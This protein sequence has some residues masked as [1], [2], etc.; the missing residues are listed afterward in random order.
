RSASRV[1]N[2]VPRRR[3]RVYAAR[4]RLNMSPGPLVTASALSETGMPAA[5]ARLGAGAPMPSSTSTMGEDEAVPPLSA[6]RFR[7]AS[8]WG[9]GVVGVVERVDVGRARIEQ[10]VRGEEGQAAFGALGAVPAHV[11]GDLKAEFAGDP[12]LAE[13]PLLV[14][15]LRAAGGECHGQQRVRPV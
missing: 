4:I 2:S 15:D 14:A 8:G 5:S 9:E 3:S 1:V 13:G 11:R 7:A 12:P 6:S 10:V